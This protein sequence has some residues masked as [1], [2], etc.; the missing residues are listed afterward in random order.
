[1]WHCVAG[2]VD[3][4]VVGSYSGRGS[5]VLPTV[6]DYLPDERY[7]PEELKMSATLL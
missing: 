1:M 7:V 2:K 3:P 4:N 6:R 5:L